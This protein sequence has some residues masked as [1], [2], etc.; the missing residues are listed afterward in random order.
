[1]RRLGWKGHNPKSCFTL[2]VFPDLHEIWPSAMETAGP[3]REQWEAGVG[4]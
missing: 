1:M 3:N 4:Q 2:P